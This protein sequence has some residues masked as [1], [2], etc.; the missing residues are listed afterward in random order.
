MIYKFLLYGTSALGLAVILGV[1]YSF[2]ETEYR[3]WR[4]GITR[5]LQMQVDAQERRIKRLEKRR[6]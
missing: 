4:I 3:I 6:P 5:D 2:I 1:V